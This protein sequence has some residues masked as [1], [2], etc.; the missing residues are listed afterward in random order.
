MYA[1]SN[2]EKSEK[3]SLPSHAAMVN[4]EK[5]PVDFAHGKNTLR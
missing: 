3:K 4:R 1:L 5:K 2:R